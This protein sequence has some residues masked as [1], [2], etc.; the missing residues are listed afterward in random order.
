VEKGGT[1][2]LDR[3]NAVAF[4][5]TCP[6]SPY[7]ERVVISTE[8]AHALCERRSGETPHFVFVFAVVFSVALFF[9]RFPPKNRM[10]SPKTIKS[11]SLQPKTS[12]NKTTY[13]KK[14]NPRKVAF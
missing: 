10:S 6:S 5:V 8:A 12:T 14:I 11:R 1:K 13:K 9:L 3:H 2:V 7:L 4:A